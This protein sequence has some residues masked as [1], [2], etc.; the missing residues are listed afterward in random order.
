MDDNILLLSE[1]EEDLNVNKS[2]AKPLASKIILN[3]SL[4]GASLI[5]SIVLLIM[6]FSAASL[7]DKGIISDWSEEECNMRVAMSKHAKV[8]AFMCDSSK[9]S[10]T[11]AFKLFPVS[12]VDYIITDAPLNEKLFAIFTLNL[13]SDSP[14]YLYKVEKKKL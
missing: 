14:A 9:F 1:E 2:K 8:K 13:V 4:F 7:S 5:I 12:K 10:T 3:W 11:S 6:F